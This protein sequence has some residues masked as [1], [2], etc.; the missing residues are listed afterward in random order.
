MTIIKPNLVYF[1]LK[2]I[3]SRGGYFLINNQFCVTTSKF[4]KAKIIVIKDEGQALYE[5]EIPPNSLELRLPFERCFIEY[6]PPIQTKEGYKI[7]GVY[8]IEFSK[9]IRTINYMFYTPTPKL[10]LLGCWEKKIPPEDDLKKT[11]IIRKRHEVSLFEN[12]LS[13]LNCQ[14]VRLIP[15]GLSSKS[16]RKRIKKGLPPTPPPYHECKVTF[17]LV[18]RFSNRTRSTEQKHIFGYQFDVRG[19]FR[20]LKSP[21]FIH[22]K[23]KLVW[24]HPYRKGQDEYIPKTYIFKKMQN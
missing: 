18:R 5:T 12:T 3:F 21:R 2:S 10:I 7:A 8:S 19:H 20:L 9:G 6:V 24:V 15:C 17:P 13:F 23:E 11:V 16:E 22:K 14:N 1:K 4:N